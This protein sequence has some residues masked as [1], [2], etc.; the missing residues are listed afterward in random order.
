MS[1]LPP[2][3]DSAVQELFARIAES[4]GWVSNLLGALGHS[5]KALDAFQRLGHFG[6]YETDLTERERELVIVIAGRSVPYAW[7]HHAPLAMQVGITETQL[8]K[9]K[10]GEVPEGLSASEAALCAYCLAYTSFKGIPDDVFSTLSSH[11]SNRQVTDISVL[12][13]Y[14][15]GAGAILIGLKIVTEPPEVLQ[16]EL[17]WQKKTMAASD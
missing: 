14:Y 8:D 10:R 1:R 11:Y 6:R 16:I 5:P 4:R 17:D 2:V 12:S 9:I 7:A 3:E 15:L 13:S